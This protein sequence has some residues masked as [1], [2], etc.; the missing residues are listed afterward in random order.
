MQKR[1][2]IVVLVLGGL[3]LA[4]P[5]WTQDICA[6]EGHPESLGDFTTRDQDTYPEG[7]SYSTSGTDRLFFPPNDDGVWIFDSFDVSRSDGTVRGDDAV[8]VIFARNANNDPIRL[9]VASDVTIAAGGSRIEVN[10]GTGGP[11]VANLNGKGAAGGPGGF[12]GGDGAYLDQ[13]GTSDG[14]DGVGPGGGAGGD[15]ATRTDALGGRFLGLEELRPLVGGSG[16]GG[17]W[18]D[19]SGNCSAG[20]GGGAG[21]AL[22]I[23]ANGT[24]DVSGEIQAMGGNGGGA[25]SGCAGRG[26][27]GSGGA[28][29]LVA[30]RLAG[31]GTITTAGGTTAPAGFDGIVRLEA[32]DDDYSGTT[33]PVASRRPAPGPIVN[34]VTPTVRIL[35]VNGDP[36]P[37][38]PIGY[39]GQID[40]TLDAPGIQTFDLET[41]DVPAGTEVEVTVKP[42]TRSASVRTVVQAV[43]LDAGSCSTDGVCS[44]VVPIDLAAGAYIVEAQATFETPAP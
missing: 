41:S 25:S 32:I 17:G 35:A 2:T 38:Q 7:F 9:L 21:G 37:A 15:A 6:C 3:L 11:G 40:L 19:D 44:A 10:G 39:L 33:T 28:I 26:G 42:K 34:P 43:L 5:A 18:S 13:T 8:R 30:R 4:P 31:D 29:R 12:A 20:G 27:G 24:I 16:G 36:T 23:A 14:G 1:L 22:L